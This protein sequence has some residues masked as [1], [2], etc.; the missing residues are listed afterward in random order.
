M[1]CLR[2]PVNAR[3]TRSLRVSEEPM[4]C[5]GYRVGVDYNPRTGAACIGTL[6]SQ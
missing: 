2:L 5:L 6:P 1:E 3:K 4:E